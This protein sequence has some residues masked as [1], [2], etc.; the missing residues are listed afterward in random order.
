MYTTGIFSLRHDDVWLSSF[1]KAG[2]TW[3]RFFLCNLI[4]LVDFEGTPVDFQFVAN[5]MPSLGRSNLRE[6]KKYTCLPR[7]IKTHQPYRNIL[8]GKP[9]RIV[10]IMRDPRDIMVSYY[11][12][13]KAHLRYPYKGDFSEF[14]RSPIYGLEACL[15]HYFSWKNKSLVTIKYELLKQNAVIEFQGMLISLGI[16]LPLDLIKIAVTRSTF[17]NMKRIQ[18]NFG[19][20]GHKRFREEFN[21]VRKGEVNQWRDYFSSDD[22][23]YYQNICEKFGF[24]IY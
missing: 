17:E 18:T 1:P 3:L 4:S 9:Q 22:L 21:V 5:I 2:S 13:Q 14:I 16:H 6:Q 23:A 20:A 12:F 7:F 11:H 10:Y 8:F 19:I 15:S 24:L